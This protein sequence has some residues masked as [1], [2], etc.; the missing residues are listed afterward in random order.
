MKKILAMLLAVV[1]SVLML[2]SCGEYEGLGSYIENYPEKPD[3][4]EKLT[5]NLYIITD[6]E[7]TN[8]AINTVKRMVTQH[9]EYTYTTELIV[10]YVTA[11]KYDATVAAAVDATD[12]TAAN[13]VL[14]NSKELMN[15]LV[16][17]NKLAD[18]SDY[19]ET[20]AY[21]SLNSQIPKALLD[22]SRINNK[23]YCIPNNHLIGE[24]KYL[25][26]DKAYCRDELHYSDSKLLS[27]KTLEDAAD[28]IDEITRNGKN[29][30][31]YVY[32][33]SGNY[34]LKAEIEKEGAKGKI[35]NVSVYPTVDEDEAF[36][37]AFAVVNGQQKYVDRAMQMIYAI[38]N[39]AELRNLLQYGVEG[40][41]YTVEDGK[42]V[43]VDSGD[44]LY[45]MN[46]VYTG[47]VFFAKYCDSLG[48]DANA[49][50]NASKQNNESV[51]N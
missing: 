34:E 10:N 11:D 45:H 28:L 2:V 38:N 15:S 32:Y 22:G 8:F 12:A 18:L 21:G 37:S 13:I 19:L 27:Y 46:L 3:E 35:C 14:I 6:A 41:N 43:R 1:F 33:Q 31:D 26:I 7:T 36:S 42:V 51:M 23:N 30:D 44:N 40:T 17:A 50:E 24:Y 20:K 4:V 47:D 48:W 5:L 25:V 39:D 9:T 49:A 16:S 29:P